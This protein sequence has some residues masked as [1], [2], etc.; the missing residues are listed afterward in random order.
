LLAGLSAQAKRR[1]SVPSSVSAQS[2][3]QVH[4]C[5][6]EAYITAGGRY[7]AGGLPVGAWREWQ[8]G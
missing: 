8:E 7:F 2:A 5:F 1:P 6:W 4:T 3:D